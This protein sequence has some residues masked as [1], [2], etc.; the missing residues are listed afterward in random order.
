MI[1]LI[2]RKDKMKLDRVQEFIE[3]EKIEDIKEAVRDI[4]PE[5]ASVITGI[6]AE[7]I[8]TLVDEF[9][10]ADSAVCYGRLGVSA[11]EHGALSHWAINVINVL[12]GN[13]D[14]PGGAMLSSPAINLA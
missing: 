2:I 11:T 13:F 5:V 14:N 1:N 12:T 7:S 9:T 6:R 8:E 4:T 3:L 10:A